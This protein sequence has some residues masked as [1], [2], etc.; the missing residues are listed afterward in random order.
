MMKTVKAKSRKTA[1]RNPVRKGLRRVK[2]QAHRVARGRTSFQESVAAGIRI[3]K[4]IKAR[5]A[6]KGRNKT[7]IKAKRVTVLNGKSVRRKYRNG[8]LDLVIRGTAE[9][10]AQGWR[11]GKK[12]IPQG[13]G[14]TPL[15]SGYYLD[16]ATGTVFAKRARNVA[17]G[18]YDGSGVFHPIRSSSDYDAGTVG[19]T[20]G[21]ARHTRSKKK[22]A[23][24]RKASATARHRAETKRRKSTTTR[25]AGRALSRSVSL[26]AG[27]KTQKK[28][29]P[30]T[31]ADNRREFAGRYN[32]DRDLFFPQGTPAGLSKLGKLTLLKTDV[33]DIAPVKGTAWLCRDA[34]GK[35]HIGTTSPNAVLWDGPAQ[36]LG[37]VKRLEYEES[38]PHLG[39]PNPVVW[40]HRMGE[41]TGERPTLHADGK[42]GLKFRGGRYRI[43]SRGIV[44]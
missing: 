28:R 10:T 25:L 42:G 35:L 7:I 16:K 17:A 15:S 12:T 33:G 38:K 4:R 41:E 13:K 2:R 22:L 14:I 40:F 5:R 19:E 36:S 39:Y 9:K 34:A 24:S 21:K 27:S 31:P 6:T 1:S 29:N 8:Y 26:K 23:A 30:N 20:G 37:Q 44:N 32:G 3:K 18:F 11:V 43:E